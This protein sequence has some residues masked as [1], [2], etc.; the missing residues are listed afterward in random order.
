MLVYCSSTYKELDITIGRL[1]YVGYVIPT[2]C[3]FLSQ[4]RRLK[5][6]SKFKRH[7]TI[8]RLVLSDLHLWLDF[9][10]K[11]HKGI[12]MNLITYHTLN[13]VYCSDSCEHGLGCYCTTEKAWR[14]IIPTHLLSR[15]HINLLKFIAIIVCIWLNYLYNYIPPESC[16]LCL[17]DSTTSSGWFQKSNFQKED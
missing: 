14:W 4:I 8:L 6:T 1:N 3:H 15:A 10:S 13:H 7:C 11:A 17:G 5:Y 2:Y 12:S 9:L 16:L